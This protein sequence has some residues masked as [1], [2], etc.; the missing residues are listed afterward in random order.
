MNPSLSLQIPSPVQRIDIDLYREKNLEVYIKREDL[1]HPEVSGNKWR[2]L[3]YNIEQAKKENKGI[4]TFGG[5]F[6]NHIYATAHAARYFGLPCIGLIR[7]KY[8]D[9]NNP[10][11]SAVRAVG[12]QLELL[13][14][15]EYGKKEEEDFLEVLQKKYPDYLIIPEGGN[16][17][18]AIEGLKELGKEINDLAFT[19]DL[20]LVPAGTASTAR[21]LLRSIPKQSQLLVFSSLKGD[22]LNDRLVLEE[23]ENWILQTEFHFGGYACVNADLINTINTFKTQTGIPLDPI[24]T[25]KMLYGFHALLERGAIEANSKILL[26]HTGGLQGILGHNI[27]YQ[28]QEELRIQ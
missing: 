28:A 24:Y 3:K 19:P 2:K 8:V 23:N 27:K 13:S 20:I 6:S 10:S 12:M 18:K 1:I 9:L 11:L 15:E 22:F 26:I 5:A 4:L 16:N 17:A 25:A 21:G 7:G 14:R